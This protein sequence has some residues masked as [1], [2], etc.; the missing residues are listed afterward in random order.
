GVTVVA[1]PA[2]A[3]PTAAVFARGTDNAAWYRQFTE[4]G[5]PAPAGWHSLGGRL[6]S[7]V[8]AVTVP[9]GQTYVF[10]LGTDNRAWMAHGIWPAVRGWTL[11]TRAST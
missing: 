2:S 1:T 6:T 5:Y 9:G 10:V 7:G 4:P 11:A 3:P 8:T